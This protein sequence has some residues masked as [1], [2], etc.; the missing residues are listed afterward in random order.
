MNALNNNKRFSKIITG[1]R[2]SRRKP[3]ADSHSNLPCIVTRERIRTLR[4][5]RST[6]QLSNN[7][8][9]NNFIQTKSQ[10][11]DIEYMGK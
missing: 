5:S 8:N 3:L 2:R 11:W 1:P 4:N 7:N 10:Y 6:P 9:N